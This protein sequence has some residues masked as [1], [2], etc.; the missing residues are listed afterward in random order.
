MN[1]KSLTFMPPQQSLI[2]T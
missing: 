2:H 1:S